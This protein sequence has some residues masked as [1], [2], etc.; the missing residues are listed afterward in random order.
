MT[1]TIQDLYPAFV[2]SVQ[3]I[4][5]TMVFMPII[6]EEPLPVGH[7]PPRGGIAGSLSITGGELTINLSLVFG[8]ELAFTIFRAM[9]GMEEADPVQMEEVS[10]IVGELANMTS[11]GAKTRMQE[12]YPHLQLGLPSVV[13][14]KDLYVDPPKNAQTVIVPLNAEPG[15]FFLEISLH[16]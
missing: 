14:G 8:T 4:F 10:D 16:A 12:D 3:E 5:E 9:M 7:E 2:E 13:V 1:K 15:K 11:G 6:A